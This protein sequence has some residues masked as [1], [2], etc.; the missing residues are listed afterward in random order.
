MLRHAYDRCASFHCAQER[1]HQI[2]DLANQIM[3]AEQ[4][5]HSMLAMYGQ[6]MVG[7]QYP[8]GLAP[9]VMGQ[10][11]GFAGMGMQ[12]QP[13]VMPAMHPMQ[14]MGMMQPGLVYPGAG[15]VPLSSAPMVMMGQNPLYGMQQAP[16]VQQFPQVQ[17]PATA[18]P[19]LRAP[20]EQQMPAPG[21]V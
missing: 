4:S 6:P 17:R 13:M 8:G 11:M 20:E 7:M 3:A 1:Q 21:E 9:G 16:Q 10:P 19:Q 2:L 18:A 5:T 12:P 15:M 14:A